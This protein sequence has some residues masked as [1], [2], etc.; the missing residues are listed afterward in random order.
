MTFADDGARG[1]LKSPFFTDIFCERP[2][3]DFFGVGGIVGYLF[4]DTHYIMRFIVPLALC[5]NTS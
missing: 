4:L 1:G 3:V 2:I 5:L